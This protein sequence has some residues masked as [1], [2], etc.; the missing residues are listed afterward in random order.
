LLIEHLNCKLK[1]NGFTYFVSTGNI[2][3]S[4]LW[5][6][7]KSQSSLPLVISN[8][9]IVSDS[10]N[11]SDLALNG[12][13]Q[14]NGFNFNY[15]DAKLKV[16]AF[17]FDK[18]ALTSLGASLM[19]DISQA[20][21]T[22]FSA[23]FYNGRL[24]GIIGVDYLSQ[25]SYS[26]DVNL[27][28][29]DIAQ[30]ALVVPSLTSLKGIVQGK[31]TLRGTDDQLI[32]LNAQ[33][34]ELQGGQMKAE[35]LTYLAQYIP[36]RQQIEDLIKQNADIPLD[37]G[38]LTISSITDKKLATQIKLLSSKLNLDMNVTIDINIEDGLVSLLQHLKQ[39]SQ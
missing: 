33:F 29:V 17:E 35:L 8:L 19:V 12:Q 18:Y 28:K 31:I 20:K 16:R 13:A 24:N 11:V 38:D 15:L 1:I 30:L 2:H 26:I 36:Q 32:E 34:N 7:F 27:S 21:L 37:R 9:T 4:N 3:V 6:L 5:H 22:D 39:L 10:V 25:I 14:F 23:E